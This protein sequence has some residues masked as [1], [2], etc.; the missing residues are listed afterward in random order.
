MPDDG[1]IFDE[2]R[3][4]LDDAPA[5]SL[6]DLLGRLEAARLRGLARLTTPGGQVS[7][8]RTSGAE[9]VEQDRLLTLPEVAKVLGVPVEHARELGRRGALPITRLGQRS[10]RV[11]RSSLDRFVREREQRASPVWPAPSTAGRA[12][13]FKS[14]SHS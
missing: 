11:R 3:K 4:L 7:A 14:R 6:P 8:S 9:A 12:V 1:R 10:V 5:A 13:A 2:L